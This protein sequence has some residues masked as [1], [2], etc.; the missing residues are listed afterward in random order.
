MCS[1]TFA[2]SEHTSIPLSCHVSGEQVQKLEIVA[3]TPVG[4]WSPEL[5]VINACAE[6]RGP[7][8]AHSPPRASPSAPSARAVSLDFDAD[9]RVATHCAGQGCKLGGRDVDT[10]ASRV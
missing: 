1:S 4:V 3:S 2:R 6:R 10:P 7:S 9:L 5:H 8:R